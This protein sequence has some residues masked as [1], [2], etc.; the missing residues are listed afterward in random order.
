MTGVL[1][2]LAI[3]VFPRDSVPFL[4]P[5]LRRLDNGG[6]SSS[7]EDGALDVCLLLEGLL[8]LLLMPLEVFEGLEA[9]GRCYIQHQKFMIHFW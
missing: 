3:G 7:S 5:F 4:D 9:T 2:R 6:S 8:C 1:A